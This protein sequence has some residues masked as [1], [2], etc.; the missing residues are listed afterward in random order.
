[1]ISS[2]TDVAGATGA[3]V[4]GLMSNASSGVE[5]GTIGFVERFRL[6]G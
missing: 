2:F 4:E 5:T 3:G 1:L 6:T